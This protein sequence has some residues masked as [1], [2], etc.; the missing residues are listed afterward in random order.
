MQKSKRLLA[1]L[2]AMVMMLATMSTAMVA[3]AEEAP[4]EKTAADYL[5]GIAGELEK[6]IPADFDK[7][8]AKA[9]LDDLANQLKKGT[10]SLLAETEVDDEIK[11]FLADNNISF[12]ADVEPTEKAQVFMDIIDAVYAEPYTEAM[13]KA[14]WY[15]YFGVAGSD[16]IIP[17]NLRRKET[18]GHW[19][20]LKTVPADYI[21]KFVKVTN[22]YIDLKKDKS[23]YDLKGYQQVAATYPSGADWN[24]VNT[25]LGD[26]D[27]VLNST[28]ADLLVPGATS[29]QEALEKGVYT[30]YAVTQVDAM[31][32]KLL[33]GIDLSG[34]T[35]IAAMLVGTLKKILITYP[36]QVGEGF[37]E[38]SAA[39]NALVN[40]IGGNAQSDATKPFIPTN[41]D[42]PAQ[43][44][45][46]RA[47]EL[48]AAIANNPD[49]EPQPFD[50]YW[51]YAAQYGIDYGF[52]DGDREGFIHAL[53][54]SLNR[55]GAIVRLLLTIAPKDNAQPKAEMA[56]W[57][58]GLYDDVAMILE[59]LGAKEL[60]GDD[61]MTMADFETYI[62]TR[63]DAKSTKDDTST[64]EFEALLTSVFDFVEAIA[65]AP[66]TNLMT[67]L[68]R[69]AYL[70]NHG[71]L[72]TYLNKAIQRNQTALW[73]MAIDAI[74]PGMYPFNLDLAFEYD[75]DGNKVYAPVLDA[76]GNEVFDAEGYPVEKAVVNGGLF[77]LLEGFIDPDVASGAAARDGVITMP[78]DLNG[79][80]LNITLTEEGVCE[81][82]E[83]LAHCN[84]VWADKSCTSRMQLYIPVFDTNAPDAF[85]QTF[86]WAFKFLTSDVIGAAINDMAASSD[87]ITALALQ[88]AAAAI[89][90]LPADLAMVAIIE[91]LTPSDST[92]PEF[93]SLPEL[94]ELPELPGLPSI[95]GL[96]DIFGQIGDF[97]ENIFN[98]IFG[99]GNG[100]NGGNDPDI[101]DTSSGKVNTA[102]AVVALLGVAGAGAVILKRRNDD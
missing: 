101:P 79:T 40:E 98:S 46:E 74:I 87:P 56:G 57:Q 99:G 70:V 11:T 21:E 34:L 76:N 28:I 61:F 27:P 95:P 69:A 92:T 29:I 18:V 38:D 77:D 22:W 60:L 5:N 59:I 82:I 13:A 31:L 2:L 48:W 93:P 91:A 63:Q 42:C 47:H 52:K 49:P 100:G 53:S 43:K 85:V 80:A 26:M 64:L 94:P 96:G 45:Y 16:T 41:P 12:F 102:F 10:E 72:T 90:N 84:K 51:D 73:D 9:Q 7:D 19:D 20:D 50:F 67:V 89:K 17:S 62:R 6:Y 8:A 66:A 68:P 54:I 23:P 86:N 55:V 32:Y 39:Y 3:F 65:E 30:N 33:A 97:F 83:A 4:A 15:A 36:N 37:A 88:A 35:G 25:F 71:D 75:A 78:I 24:R 14:L 44:N 81:L 58:H 1:V